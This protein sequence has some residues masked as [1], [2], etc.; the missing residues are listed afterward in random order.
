MWPF[1]KKNKM[2]FEYFADGFGVLSKTR[3]FMKSEAFEKAWEF[4][5]KNS[6]TGWAKTGGVPDIRWRSHIAIWA[7]NHGLSLEGDFVECGVFT[8]ILSLSI[9]KYLQ[10][11]KISK[12]FWL[13]DGWGCIPIDSV[14]EPE[15][16]AVENLNNV[17]YSRDNVFEAAVNAFSPYPNCRLIRGMLPG[18]LASSPEKISYLS[19]DLNNAPAEKA[20][21]EILWPRLSNGAIVVIDDYAWIGHE[22]QRDMWDKFAACHNQLVATL[23]TGQGLLIKS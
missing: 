20:C 9:C 7:A 17:L 4:A 19:I 16:F 5:S 3:G 2:R 11:E 23:P 12:N 13:Y 21:I 8:G 10:F 14:E 18:T 1:K 6:E 15:R 22:L